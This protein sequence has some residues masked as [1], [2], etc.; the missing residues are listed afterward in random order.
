MDPF[1]ADLTLK[2]TFASPL[3]IIPLAQAW[4]CHNATYVLYLSVELVLGVSTLVV[5]KPFSPGTH[6]FEQQS[7]RIHQTFV[8]NLDMMSWPKWHH[9]LWLLYVGVQLFHFTIFLFGC[10]HNIT[11]CKVATHKR[12]GLTIAEAQTEKVP[13]CPPL[14]LYAYLSILYPRQNVEHF[15]VPPRVMGLFERVLNMILL[16]PSSP[17]CLRLYVQTRSHY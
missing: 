9:Q 15:F 4:G 14:F 8:I 11:Y 6:V 1:S 2:E 3:D 10:I 12:E 17:L 13:L 7:A 5:L 16:F